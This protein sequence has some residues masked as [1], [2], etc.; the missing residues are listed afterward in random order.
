MKPDDFLMPILLANP[1]EFCEAAR[2][3][4]ISLMKPP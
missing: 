2:E 1:D 4:R 3:H